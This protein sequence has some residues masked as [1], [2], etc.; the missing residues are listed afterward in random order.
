[1]K[2][3]G[4]EPYYELLRLELIRTTK[5]PLSSDSFTGW[6]RGDP[7]KEELEE[8]TRATTRILHEERIPAFAKYFT[9]RQLLLENCNDVC[10]LDPLG[11]LSEEGFLTMME[12]F[13][14]TTMLHVHGIN[15]RHV[16]R[17]RALVPEEA[18]VH[19]ILL[20]CYGVSRVVV[21]RMKKDMR[22]TMEGLCGS[23]SDI[24]FRDIAL[25]HIN[26][27]LLRDAKKY[28]A[29]VKHDLGKRYPGLLSDKERSEDF[30]M[31]RAIDARTTLYMVS[32]KAGLQYTSAMKKSILDNKT[33]VPT[34]LSFADM[35]TT[36]PVVKQNFL[37]YWAL[38]KYSIPTDDD[39]RKV[40]IR[41]LQKAEVNVRKALARL[42]IAAELNLL[43]STV[44]LD[45]LELIE[46]T[47][48]TFPHALESAI[49]GLIRATSDFVANPKDLCETISHFRRAITLYRRVRENRQ[50]ARSPYTSELCDKLER[51]LLAIKQDKA[52]CPI[53][54][55]TLKT[56]FEQ[57]MSTSAKD[58]PFVY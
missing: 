40:R 27:L 41:K 38:A 6:S 2:K 17:V 47:D 37:S 50:V 44:I 36:K 57:A 51:H 22:R 10:Y 31:R 32:K 24:P 19:R 58:L 54:R 46:V 45:R 15:V 28:W 49:T 33:S 5:T 8:R 48:P 23:P 7:K 21:H 26:S 25:T 4:R 13:D 55:N 18:R 12:Q 9:S 3:T 56:E 29:R 1:V 43:H 35:R 16:G 42:P 30:C 52:M 53:M 34:Y 20:L 14:V 11:S 39:D